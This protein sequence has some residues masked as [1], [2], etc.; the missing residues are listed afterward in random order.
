MLSITLPCILL[1]IRIEHVDYYLS[2]LEALFG[3]I[4]SMTHY[5]VRGWSY[6]LW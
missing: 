6:G 4:S 5:V 2:P 3:N 1:S